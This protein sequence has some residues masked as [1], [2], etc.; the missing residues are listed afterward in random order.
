MSASPDPETY[1][2]VQGVAR[3]V[4]IKPETVRWYHKRGQMPKAD[5][6]FGRSPVW[7]KSTI[8]AWAASRQP[9]PNKTTNT[10]PEGITL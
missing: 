3:K 5:R 10:V 7:E 2:D 6:Y 9:A 8:E 4:H 1:L